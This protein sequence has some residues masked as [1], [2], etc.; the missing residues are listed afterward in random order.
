MGVRRD[1]R[2][3][4]QQRLDAAAG[5]DAARAAARHTEASELA[6]AARVVVAHSARVAKRLEHA[7]RVE[8][9]R[10]KPR[11]LLLALGASARTRRGAC[12]GVCRHS[13]LCTAAAHVPQHLTT[14]FRLAGSGLTVHDDC[15]VRAGRGGA[16]PGSL[17][18]SKDVRGRRGWVCGSGHGG[19]PSGE[20]VQARD[21]LEWV[22][23]QEH[24]A[25]PRVDG[26]PAEA[27]AQQL[28][29]RRLVEIAHERWVI[30]VVVVGRVVQRCLGQPDAHRLPA[31]ETDGGRLVS[32]FQM[33]GENP[34]LPPA[35]VHPQP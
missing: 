35:F 3:L 14:R 16:S 31:C 33:V 25:S 13:A 20:G 10:L 11:H 9:G 18:H 28:Q 17:C 22:D 23:G 19:G 27:A 5:D 2:A 15:H 12:S 1:A 4:E 29:E 7:S 6:E 30:P 8:H 34:R 26:A 24:L 32:R 21:V